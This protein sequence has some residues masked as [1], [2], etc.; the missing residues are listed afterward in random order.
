M[1]EFCVGFLVGATLVTVVLGAYFVKL[2]GE[3]REQIAEL[4]VDLRHIER[5]FV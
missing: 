1:V 3:L 2:T 5:G 4:Q